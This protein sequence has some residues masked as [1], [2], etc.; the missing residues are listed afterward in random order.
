MSGKTKIER[1]NKMSILTK[2]IALTLCISTIVAPYSTIA[3]SEPFNAGSGTA[4]ARLYGAKYDVSVSAE[5]LGPTPCQAKA[6]V[7][8]TYMGASGHMMWAYGY[9]TLSNNGYS[10][11]TAQFSNCASC[12]W[13]G[14]EGDHTVIKDG[15]T[16]THTTNQSL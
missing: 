3:R 2:I 7:C 10:Y 11:A 14:V 16:Y 5:T 9:G 15:F 12:Y 8:G 6:D 13:V 1:K 4:T